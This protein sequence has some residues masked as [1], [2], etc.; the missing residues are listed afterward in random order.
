MEILN[1][2]PNTLQNNSLIQTLSKLLCVSQVKNGFWWIPNV[3][4]T[5]MDFSFSVS[6]FFLRWMV[7]DVYDAV[8]WMLNR[9]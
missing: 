6:F 3:D 9:E 8:Q 4:D 2:F 1:W 7:N 5:T